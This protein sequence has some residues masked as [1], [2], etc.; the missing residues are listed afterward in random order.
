MHVGKTQGS[1]P[2]LL[3]CLRILGQAAKGPCQRKQSRLVA[4]FLFFK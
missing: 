1:A 2:G 3:F 4:G